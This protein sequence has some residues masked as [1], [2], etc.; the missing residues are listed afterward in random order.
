[1]ICVIINF[2]IELFYTTNLLNLTMYSGEH[3]I[4]WF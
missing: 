4:Q 2:D 3:F 1:M